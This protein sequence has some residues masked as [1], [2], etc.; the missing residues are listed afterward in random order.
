MKKKERELKVIT[1]IANLGM[2][3]EQMNIQMQYLEHHIDE[4]EQIDGIQALTEILTLKEVC[5]TGEKIKNKKA[6][7]NTI[8]DMLD[9]DG[10]N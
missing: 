5:E 4:V 1:S 2:M 10:Y 3:M 9:P 6:I 8:D 7:L